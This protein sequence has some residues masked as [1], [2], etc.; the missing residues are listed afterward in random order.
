MLCERKYLKKR[1]DLNLMKNGI[2]PFVC[3]FFLCLGIVTAQ[4]GKNNSSKKKI[5]IGLI[6]KMGTNPVFIAAN[7]GAKI[8]AKELGEKYNVNVVINWAT[9]TKEN[10][11]EQAAAIERLVNAGVNGIAL[12]CSDANYLTPIIDKVVK[13]GI[14]IICFDSDAPKSTRF[15]YYGADDIEFGRLL[16]RGLAS[17]IDEKGMI[18]VLAGN[19]N[20]L[21]LNRRL[22][23]IQE[24]LKKYRNIVLPQNNIINNLDVPAIASETVKRIQKE[25]PKIKGWIFITS[26]ALQVKNSLKWKPGEVKVVAGNAIPVELE[27]VKSGYVQSL[28][29]VNCFQYGYK[30]VEIL[31]DKI[32]KNKTPREQLIYSPLTAVTKREVNEW[33]L[34]WNKWL[35]KEA[36]K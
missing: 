36:L 28:V 32:I 5:T 31:L 3:I 12:S 21:N 18:A 23:G 22:Q 20:A 4:T 19:K 8:A 14:P 25:N 13:K 15:A 34:N 29:G 6:G 35:L 9:P 17:E 24:E 27:Y 30:S 2:I 33:S 11:E 16:M 7:S 26:A 10:V 1:K